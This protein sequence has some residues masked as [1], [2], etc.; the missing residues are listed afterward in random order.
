[1]RF[2]IKGYLHMSKYSKE[3]YAWDIYFPI[4]PSIYEK[5]INPNTINITVLTELNDPTLYFTKYCIEWFAGKCEKHYK[6][7]PKDIHVK[8]IQVGQEHCVPLGPK[9]GCSKNK[10]NL[11][12]DYLSHP[13]GPPDIFPDT[14]FFLYV[15]FN[16]KATRIFLKTPSLY[17]NYLRTTCQDYYS[18][19]CIYSLGLPDKEVSR[20]HTTLPKCP[21]RGKKSDI[22]YITVCEQE[23]DNYQCQDITYYFKTG[24]L[25]VSSG[26]FL[27]QTPGT[28]KITYQNTPLSICFLCPHVTN[29]KYEGEIYLD[30][31]K[32]SIRL[33]VWQNYLALVWKDSGKCGEKKW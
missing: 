4:Q 24:S 18:S 30:F 1:M 28:N 31:T 2:I 8:Y 15:C 32:P 9:I 26:P 22:S 3:K 11:S 29:I 14:K 19:T 5:I 25:N 13:P 20:C 27:I 12:N 33:E 21:I 10:C 7:C 16:I 23:E 6:I 17:N